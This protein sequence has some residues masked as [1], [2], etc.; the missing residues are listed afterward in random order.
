MRANVRKKVKAR[1]ARKKMKP[2]K[3]RTKMKARMSRAKMAR[4]K[5]RHVRYVIQ[6]A[7]SY[8]IETLQINGPLS[9]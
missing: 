8:H 2:R 9:I 4:K 7:R 3:S 1:K 5:Q 6:H